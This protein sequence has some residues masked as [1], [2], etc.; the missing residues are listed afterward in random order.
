MMMAS[1]TCGTLQRRPPN[2]LQGDGTR[3]WSL[4]ILATLG[5]YAAVAAFLLYDAPIPTATAPAAMM[6][7]LAPVP[8]AQVVPEDLQVAPD[9]TVTM[10]SN[11]AMPAKP[12]ALAKQARSQAQKPVPKPVA[13]PLQS[14]PQPARETLV[15]PSSTAQPARQNDQDDADQTSPA[16]AST[17]TAPPKTEAMPAERTAASQSSRGAA[18]PALRAQ[19]ESQLLAHIER[20]KRYPQGAR[21]R[22]DR[23]TAYL[24]FEI[25]TE[26]Q[27]LSARI[28][29]SSGLAELD[30]AALDMIHRAS[31]VP[32]PPMGSAS[33]FTVPVVFAQ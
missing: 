26:G 27:V 12:R 11:A 25:D 10:P 5:V 18:D 1:T 8:V 30:Q 17:A 29:R 20:F 21:E 13:H 14:T 32:R 4:A 31:P 15:S 9:K 2:Y 7:E 6:I 19:W 33:R 23:G 24:R 16:A 3:R 28:A 22:G